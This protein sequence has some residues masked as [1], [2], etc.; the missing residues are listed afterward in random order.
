MPAGLKVHT[1]YTMA[2]GPGV[3]IASGWAPDPTGSITS[4]GP[5]VV[6][7]FPTATS[8]AN[9]RLLRVSI[10]GDLSD[11][12]VELVRRHHDILSGATDEVLATLSGSFNGGINQQ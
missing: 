7:V 8:L 10:I 4:L 12:T 6:R 5:G 3:N 1:T 2:N 11:S 9:G